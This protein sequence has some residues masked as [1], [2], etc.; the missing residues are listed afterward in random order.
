MNNNNNNSFNKLFTN[1]LSPTERMYFK[2]NVRNIQ[3]DLSNRES[4][5]Q[6]LIVNIIG[7]I[8][9]IALI[10]N[11][12]SVF[13]FFDNIIDWLAELQGLLFSLF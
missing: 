9:L 6:P 12:G 10:C 4:E 8:I 13:S 7:I 3:K 2:R 1:N 11:I 5:P